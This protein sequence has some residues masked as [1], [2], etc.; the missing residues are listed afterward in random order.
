MELTRVVGILK[1]VGVRYKFNHML[2]WFCQGRCSHSCEMSYQP[3]I[4]SC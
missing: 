3:S 2:K 4:Y 1:C